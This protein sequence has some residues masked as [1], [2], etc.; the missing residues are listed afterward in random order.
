MLPSWVHWTIFAVLMLFAIW[1]MLKRSGQPSQVMAFKADR[2]KVTVV[3]RAIA[4]L[5]QKAAARTPGVDKCRSRIYKRRGKLC[6]LIKL[7][8]KAN[9]D[10][11]EVERRLES[12]ISETLR[13]SLGFT[14]IGRIDTRVVRL[15]GEPEAVISYEKRPSPTT[16]E[17][18]DRKPLSRSFRRDDRDKE[19]DKPREAEKKPAPEPSADADGKPKALPPGEPAKPEEDGAKRYH[20]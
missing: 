18:Q 11:R 17:E 19:R 5:I 3:R 4:D 15:V 9:H 2:G 10:L 13:Y 14:N 8:L 12:Q 1:L 7:H 6:I 20:V 16:D